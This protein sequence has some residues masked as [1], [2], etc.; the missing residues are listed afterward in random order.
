ILSQELLEKPLTTS[1]SVLYNTKAIFFLGTPHRGL[2]ILSTFTPYYWMFRAMGLLAT[3]PYRKQLAAESYTLY[4]LSL[5]FGKALKQAPVNIVSCYETVPTS[6]MPTFS[7]DGFVRHSHPYP[8]LR[9]PRLIRRKIVPEK[10]AVIGLPDEIPFPIDKNHIGLARM[11]GPDDSDYIRLVAVI[12]ENLAAL[13]AQR[14]RSRP[15]ETAGARDTADPP[16]APSLVTSSPRPVMSPS[17]PPGG[18][19][20]D[21]TRPSQPVVQSL[22]NQDSMLL[23]ASIE[24]VLGV[25]TVAVDALLDLEGTQ[26]FISRSFLADH[27]ISILGGQNDGRYQFHFL[28]TKTKR[29]QSRE[30]VVVDDEDP[31]YAVI[32]APSSVSPAFPEQGTSNVSPSRTQSRFP[33]TY[34]SLHSRGRQAA[35]T[36]TTSQTVPS[37]G[38]ELLGS[39]SSRSST[40]RLES[41]TWADM[42]PN[43][44]QRTLSYLT[45]PDA[46]LTGPAM[47]PTNGL[48]LAGTLLNNTKAS[49]DTIGPRISQPSAPPFLSQLG[50]G[51]AKAVAAT[52]EQG[53]Q[54]GTIIAG[55]SAGL[56]ALSVLGT[57]IYNANTAR[58]ALAQ[59]TRSAD[60]AAR[61]LKHNKRVHKYSVGKDVA[62]SRRRKKR[63][64][65]KPKAPSSPDEPFGAEAK[66]KK[67][68][69]AQIGIPMTEKM[70]MLT[71]TRAPQRME[72][73]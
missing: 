55:V 49:A 16:E 41:K 30:F 17:P 63:V 5:A 66:G 64:K 50:S 1:S 44:E 25:G 31:M 7:N 47:L 33:S 73:M 3:L 40:P 65:R 19:D 14:A 39:P 61:T 43:Q 42:E 48:G 68:G 34:S 29:W 72:Q 9:S 38:R 56:T 58:K 10:E 59:S 2:K 6:K 54:P 22:H 21:D 70:G 60:I 13:A 51:A 20:S 71:T 24:V 46:A 37:P 8:P 15:T 28:D 27:G 67:R 69:M 36:I 4:E 18:T 35:S 45:P 52:A 57:Q 62:T 23:P 53:V 12:K 32:L 11:T 26:N